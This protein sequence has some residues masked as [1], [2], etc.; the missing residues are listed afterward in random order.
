MRTAAN[1]ISNELEDGSFTYDVRYRTG[2]DAPYA[3]FHTASVRD[4]ASLADSLNDHALGATYVNPQVRLR[5]SDA[6]LTCDVSIQGDPGA[7]IMPSHY[8]VELPHLD[9]DERPYVRDALARVYGSVHGDH[10]I[11]TQFSDE[12]EPTRWTGGKPE[13]PLT[14]EMLFD[15]YEALC[16]ANGL[17]PSPHWNKLSDESRATWSDLANALHDTGRAL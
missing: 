15:R 17:P 3:L 1:V 11:R 8:Q 14:G 10:N 13:K 9:G 4:A 16:R 7:G 5:P 12:H 2:Y 6:P